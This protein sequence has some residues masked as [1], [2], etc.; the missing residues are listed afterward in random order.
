MS[1]NEKHK[2]REYFILQNATKQSEENILTKSNFTAGH[3]I[4]VYFEDTSEVGSNSTACSIT[5]YN[6]FW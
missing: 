3:A 2:E 5:K 4:F 6:I 1:N